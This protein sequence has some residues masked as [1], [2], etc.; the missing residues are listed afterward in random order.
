MAWLTPEARDRMLAEHQ[1]GVE[2][3]VLAAR[4]GCHSSNIYAHLRRRGIPSHKRRGGRISA[5]PF[6]VS[7]LL[8]VFEVRLVS[9][10]GGGS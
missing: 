6:E 4:Y 7:P 3:T 10:P 9:R 5:V 2:V 8:P 1:A